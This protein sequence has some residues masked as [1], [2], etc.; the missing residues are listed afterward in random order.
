ME[1]YAKIAERMAT[2]PSLAIFRQFQALRA[3]NLLYMQAE[4]IELETRF[5]DQAGRDIQSQEPT[6]KL[7]SRDW[8]TLSSLNN[9]GQLSEQWKLALDIREKLESYGLEIPSPL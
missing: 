3:Q 4:L 1:G 6:E 2:L 8:L 7:Y 5:R 9:N